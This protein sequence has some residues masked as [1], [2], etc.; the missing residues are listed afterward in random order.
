MTNAIDKAIDAMAIIGVAIVLL[1]ILALFIALPLALLTITGLA[2]APT[3]PVFLA[4]IVAPF[5]ARNALA[6]L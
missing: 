5:V 6:D 2:I 1:P 3:V 4:A